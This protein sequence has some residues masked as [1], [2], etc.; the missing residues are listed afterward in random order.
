MGSVMDQ[1]DALLAVREKQERFIKM[2][3]EGF[4]ARVDESIAGKLSKILFSSYPNFYQTF[5]VCEREASKLFQDVL[6]RKDRADFTRNA[7]SGFQRFRFLFSLPGTLEKS[8]QKGEFEN[9]INDYARAKALFDQ[10][11]TDKPVINLFCYAR[12]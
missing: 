9:A 4:I 1:L 10:P 3:G 2:H 6:A 8:I 12:I 5:S 7:L 11:E